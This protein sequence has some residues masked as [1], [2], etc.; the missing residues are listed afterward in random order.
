MIRRTGVGLAVAALLIA[1]PSLFAQ[2]ETLVRG[3]IESGGY[4]AGVVRFSDVAG[5]F[6]V[7]VGGRGGWIINHTFIL[8]GGGYGLANDISI[9]PGLPGRDIEFGYGGLELTYVWASPR[10][11]HATFTALIGGGSVTRSNVDDGVFVFEPYADAVLNVTSYFRVSGGLGYR[12]VS[13][14]NFPDL[15][16]SDFASLFAELAL[17]FGK[18]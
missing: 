3:K 8:G 11:L 6:G 7:M 16:N 18:F 1:P 10:L 17:N 4:G 12:F 13:G 2:Q 5:E 15:G 14:V 9:D